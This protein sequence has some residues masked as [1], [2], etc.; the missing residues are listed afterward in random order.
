MEPR[1]APPAYRFKLELPNR[2]GGGAPVSNG[3]REQQLQ[4]QKDAMASQD[5]A[6]A[7]MSEGIGRLHNHAKAIGEEAELQNKMLDTL[8]EK[9]D[10][11]NG[12]STQVFF[13]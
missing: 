10:S 4:Y 13:R 12:K 2:S 9:V 1:R 8:D 11:A 5:A 6:L 3:S 7:Q